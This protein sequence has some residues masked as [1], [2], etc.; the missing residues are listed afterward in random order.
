[1]YEDSSGRR[2]TFYAAR[3]AGGDPAAQV[4]PQ[5]GRDAAGA[6]AAGLELTEGGGLVGGVVRHQSC[7]SSQRSASMAARQPVPAAVTAWR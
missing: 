4:G 2:V 5:L 6:V 3:N 7:A 1:M